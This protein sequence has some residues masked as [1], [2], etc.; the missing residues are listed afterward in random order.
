MLEY[1]VT[2]K[3]PSRNLR[4][5]MT[6]AERLL[7]ARLRRK[8][9]QGI[10][11]YRQKPIGNFIVDFY[12]PAAGLVIEVDGS[13]HLEVEHRVRDELRDEFL[14]EHGLTVLRFDNRQVLCETDAVVEQILWWMLDRS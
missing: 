2:L 11:F 12:A 1:N 3:E 4:S 10:Q 9:L 5:N 13:Q 7:W 14:A 8:Q 6:E